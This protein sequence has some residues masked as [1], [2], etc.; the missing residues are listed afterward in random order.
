MTPTFTVLT[1]SSLFIRKS[2]SI[3]LPFALHNSKLSLI[4]FQNFHEFLYP[5]LF[6]LQE[7]LRRF[8]FPLRIRVCSCKAF[9]S[10]LMISS[11][12]S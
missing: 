5:A 4:C 3:S 2:S 12:S 10:S 1:S 6:I 11:M 7:I 8:K 9:S